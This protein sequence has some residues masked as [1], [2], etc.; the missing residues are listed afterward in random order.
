[1]QLQL[2]SYDFKHEIYGYADT[3]ISTTVPDIDASSSLDT[4][5]PYYVHITSLIPIRCRYMCMYLYWSMSAKSYT[6]SKCDTSLSNFKYSFI[7]N[8]KCWRFASVKQMRCVFSI[9][10]FLMIRAHLQVY[11]VNAT[12][13]CWKH[14]D[15]EYSLLKKTRSKYAKFKSNYWHSIVHASHGLS[16]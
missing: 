13:H 8:L 2:D 1:M 7:F 16:N 14:I 12:S 11:A 5:V 3:P 6:C 15:G 9:A 4:G 10:Q